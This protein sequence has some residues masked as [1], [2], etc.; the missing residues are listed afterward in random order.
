MNV[1]HLSEFRATD[2]INSYSILLTSNEEW[3][4]VAHCASDTTDQLYIVRMIDQNGHLC[5]HSMWRNGIC[6]WVNPE[7]QGGNPLYGIQLVR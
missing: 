2:T 1:F 4:I 3:K 7:F 6:K 5:I